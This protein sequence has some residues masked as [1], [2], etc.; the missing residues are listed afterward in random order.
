[1]LKYVVEKAY[2]ARMDQLDAEREAQEEA[3]AEE[4]LRRAEERCQKEEEEDA[5]WTELITIEDEGEAEDNNEEVK[6]ECFKQLLFVFCSGFIGEICGGDS[7]TQNR[8]IGGLGHRIWT[9]YTRSCSPYRSFGAT[10]S[11]DRHYGRSR[12]S[13]YC[14]VVSASL[15]V[16]VLVYF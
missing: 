4:R 5:K 10:R 13:L 7:R 8:G 6:K 15:F 1:M 11:S 3:E 14:F 16:V 12:Q 2:N 9:S